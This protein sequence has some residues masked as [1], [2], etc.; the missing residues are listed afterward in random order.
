MAHL[1]PLPSNVRRTNDT[2]V[3]LKGFTEP[4]LW[5]NVLRPLSRETTKGYAFIDF[6]RDTLE[7]PLLPWQEWLALHA[8]ELN[9]DNTYRFRTIV[10]L[11]A[12]QNGKSEFSKMLCAWKM[13]VDGARLV[14]GAAQNLDVAREVLQGTYDLVEQQQALNSE[15][16]SYLT[17]NGKESL[18]LKKSMYIPFGSRYKIVA[19]TGKAGRGLTVD[20]LTMD[21]AREQRDFAAWG[22]LSKT[23]NARDKAQ[24]WLI[25]NAG[26]DES[27]LLNHLIDAATNSDDESIGFFSWSAPDDCDID[28]TDAWCQA[29]PSIGYTL[30]LQ[31]IKSAL[32][33][34]PPEVF[35]TE[36]LCQHVS[37]INSAIDLTAWG[38]CADARATLEAYRDSV[39]ACV[40]VALDGAHVTLMAGAKDGSGRIRLEPVA[41]WQSVDDARKGVPGKVMSL[42]E[43]LDKIKPQ[44]VAWFPDGPATTLGPELRSC[45]Y[46]LMELRGATTKEACQSLAEQVKSRN[47]IH[48]SDPL[49]DAHVAQSSKYMTGDGWVFAR[50]GGVGQIDAAYAAAGIVYLLRNPEPPN[51]NRLIVG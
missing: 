12:R 31:A 38:A 46:A 43:W 9:P 23:T 47:L 17:A 19:A 36:V 7:Q 6:C 1:T 48:P 24:V 20:H 39:S 4:R 22:A 27:V 32:T 45:G 25:S 11:V 42:Q 21:E 13:Y 8:L 16:Q 44:R 50:R 10:V 34:D 37:S 5:P 40:D 26:S 14:L 15:V 28:D 29:N 2:T 49:L 30:S 41:A 51:K 33:T 18:T 35:R 3:A